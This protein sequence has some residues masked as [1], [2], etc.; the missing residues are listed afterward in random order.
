VLPSPALPPAGPDDEPLE[1]LGVH[2]VPGGA[3]AAVL[4]AHADAVEVALLDDDGR[5]GWRERRVPLR[6]RR[7]GVWTASLPGVGPGQ[8]YGLRVHG[9]WA[10]ERGHRHNPAK[11]LLDPYARAV[12]GEVAWGLEVFGHAV[13]AEQWLPLAGP[14]AADGRD[15]AAHVPHGVLVEAPRADPAA[16]PR[17]PWSRTVVYEAH[18]RGLTMLHPGVPPELRGTYAALGHPAVVAHLRSLGVTALELLPVQ[19]IASEASLARRGQRNYWGYSTLSWFAPEPRYATAAARA[20]GPAAVLAE[21]AGAVAALHAAGLEVLLDVVLNH[22]AESGADGPTLG[23]RGLDAATYYRLDGA[24]RDVDSTGCGNSLDFGSPRVVQLALDSL[25]H[26][27]QAFGVDGFR[28]DL[29]PTL[30]R[31][32]DGAYRADHPFLVAAAADPVLAD[33]K[34]VAEPWDLGPDGWRT[35]SFPAPFA[36][37]NDRFRDAAREFWL[38]GAGRTSC[39]EP[40]GAGLRDLATRISG[41]ADLFAAGDRGPLASVSFVTAHDGFTLADATAFQHKV[42]EANGEGNRDGTDSNRSWNHGAEGWT[43]G[44]D[45]DELLLEALRRRSMRNLLATLLLSA[46]VPMLTGGDELGR[47]QGGNNNPYCLDDETSWVSWDLRPWQEDLLA[48]TRLLTGLRRAHPVLSPERAPGGPGA[49]EGT[50]LSWFDADGAPMAPAQWEDQ[51]LRT[52]QVLVGPA[53]GPASPGSLLLVLRGDLDDGD[54]ALPLPGAGD[55]RLLWDS[56]VERYPE[57]AV[58]SPDAA[59]SRVPVSA[60]SVRVYRLD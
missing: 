19:A 53:P 5:G 41:S 37:W 32:A 22:S 17:T 49:A 46:G 30:A 33:V 40:P 18:V 28:F 4:A 57:G 14:P 20:A 60:L 27:V 45:P 48:T 35:G 9:P 58:G 59:G 26:W 34:L 15:S 42:N 43:G 6:R 10:P 39:G 50:V 36:E 7:H 29:A 8:R 16:R 31:G 47:T 38:A 52:V 11:L 56:A 13:D 54:V 44:D 12:A 2:L 1:P 24:G 23:L 25:R 3:R 51:H 55:Y 21:V